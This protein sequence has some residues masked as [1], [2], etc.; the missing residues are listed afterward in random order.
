WSLDVAAGTSGSRSRQSLT[1]GYVSETQLRDVL[2]NGAAINPFGPTLAQDVAML[3]SIQAHG[4]ARDAMSRVS[5]LDAK[6]LTELGL[7]QTRPVRLAVGAEVRWERIHDM[8]SDLLRSGDV[9][10]IAA[11]QPVVGGHRSVASTY[12]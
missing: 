12:S 3:Q 1:S 6:G 7:W 8:A 5:W 11:T 2:A 4:L 10:G 9:L